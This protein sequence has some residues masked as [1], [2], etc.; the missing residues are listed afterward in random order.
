MSFLCFDW[1]VGGGGAQLI[2]WWPRRGWRDPEKEEEAV[3]S[4]L[5]AAQQCTGQGPLVLFP[6]VLCPTRNEKGCS[7][8][9]FTFDIFLCCTLFLI[10]CYPRESNTLFS[11]LMSISFKASAAVFFSVNV[12]MRGLTFRSFCGFYNREC[13]WL[14]LS[15]SCLSFVTDKSAELQ[16]KQCSQRAQLQAGWWCSSSQTE[17]PS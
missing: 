11:I 7:L 13:N 12:Q 17:G 6:F 8:C 16:K 2:A 9:Y 15:L 3:W 4:R 1:Q 5:W 10:R 14:S